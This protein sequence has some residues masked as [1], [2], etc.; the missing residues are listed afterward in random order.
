MKAKSVRRGLLLVG[1]ATAL[2]ACTP[3]AVINLLT[4]NSG[5][6]IQRNIAYGPDPRQAL[7][8]YVPDGLTKPAPVVLFFYGGSWENGK[9]S[10]YKAFGQAMASRGIIAVIADYRLYPQ[11]TY[12]AF[13]EDGAAAFHLIQGE[14][15][16]HGGDPKRIFLAGHSAGGYIA[17]ML[18]SDPHYLKDAHADIG[19][20][21]GIIGIA[22]PYDFLPLTDP[23]L[24]RIFHGANNEAAMPIHYID[25]V[26][27]PMLLVTGSADETVAPSN[28]ARMAARLRSR[29]SAVQEIVYPDI[30]HIGIILS[31]VP[32]FRDKTTLPDDMAKF[33]SAH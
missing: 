6:S 29:G 5:Y 2:S 13:V 14:I 31:F 9:K 17:V 25:G 32:G 30:G 19:Q 33:I 18:G 12:P 21:A 10:G 16:R 7:D 4:P 20:V 15:A 27:P 1:F 23:T 3:F 24:I 11:V 22:G 26:R 28:A 8:I